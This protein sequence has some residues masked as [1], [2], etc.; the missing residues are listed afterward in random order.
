MYFKEIQLHNFRNYEDQTVRFH[1]SVNIILGKNAQGKTNLLEGIYINSLGRSFRTGRDSE[2]VRFGETRAKVKSISVKDGKEQSIE[3]SFG[4]E[5]KEI[6]VNGKKE[7]KS[8]SLLE[9]AYIVIFSPEDL[10]I[11]QDEPEKRRRFLDRELCQLRPVYY[12]TLGDYKRL[13]LQ[14]NNLLRSGESRREQYLPWDLSLVKSGAYLIHQRALFLE[15]LDRISREI[16]GKI[17]NGKEELRL[18]YESNVPPEES[19]A[20]TEESFAALLESDL[21]RCIQKGSSLHGPQRDDFSVEVNGVDVRRFGSQGQQRT[22]ALSL[23][24][25]ETALIREE[26]GEGPVLLLDD[27]LSELDEERQKFLVRSLSEE[28]LFITATELPPVLQEDLKEGC[29]FSV[30]AGSVQRSEI[31]LTAQ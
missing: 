28:Q 3:I 5:R 2:L 25:A 4:P 8:S 11:V 20:K 9:K 15:K 16:H 13:L 12:K 19:R 26:T 7:Q 23:K 1:P 29:L 30:R 27:V 14:K 31:S 18:S 6:K 17:S 10:R 24:L 21:E 22:A